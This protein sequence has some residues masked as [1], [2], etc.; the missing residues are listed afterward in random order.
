MKITGDAPSQVLSVADIA[1]GSPRPDPCVSSMEMLMT[2]ITTEMVPTPVS[3]S[4]SLEGLD[5]ITPVE[6]VGELE[7]FLLDAVDWL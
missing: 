4:C 3:P 2:P 5:C 1:P 6:D 7:E